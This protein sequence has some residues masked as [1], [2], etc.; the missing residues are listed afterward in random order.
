[1]N[2]IGYVKFG[3]LGWAVV[4]ATEAMTWVGVVSDQARLVATKAS[5][6]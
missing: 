4:T 1:M 2:S 3:W 6:R 5:G